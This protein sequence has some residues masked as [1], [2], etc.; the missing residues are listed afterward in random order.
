MEGW[1]VKVKGSVED[2]KGVVL[3]V[4]ESVLIKMRGQL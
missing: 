3:A 2:G 1:K 4:G